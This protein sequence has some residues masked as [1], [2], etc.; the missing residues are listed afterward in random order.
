V[1]DKYLQRVSRN[2]SRDKNMR[3]AFHA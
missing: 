3:V 2:Q 1:I